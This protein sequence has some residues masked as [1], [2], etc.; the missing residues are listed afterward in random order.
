MANSEENVEDVAR[1][2]L[3]NFDP[4]PID[5]EGIQPESTQEV[6]AAVRQDNEISWLN[7]NITER[8]KSV[9]RPSAS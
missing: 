5:E 7:W 3:R 4:A 2:S 1:K 9:I 6:D 8:G